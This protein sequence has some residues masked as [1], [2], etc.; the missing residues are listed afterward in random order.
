MN[1]SSELERAVRCVEDH[2]AELAADVEWF[3]SPEAEGFGPDVK[4]F[5]AQ[6]ADFTNVRE[7]LLRLE[8]LE[9]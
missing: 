3:S 5:Q 4:V 9:S 7:Q 2:L 6:I 1:S 8:D